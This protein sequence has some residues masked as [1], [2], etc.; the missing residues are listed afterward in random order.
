MSGIP[1]PIAVISVLC[2]GLVLAALLSLMFQREPR[3][4]VCI[5]CGCTDDHACADGCWW[6]SKRPPICSR[7]A[8]DDLDTISVE[9]VDELSSVL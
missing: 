1:F 2:C 9:V 4:G 7:C 3:A 5:Y 6:W 8:P